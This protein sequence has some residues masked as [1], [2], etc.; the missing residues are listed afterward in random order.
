V[1]LTTLQTLI[2]QMAVELDAQPDGPAGLVPLQSAG[3][4]AERALTVVT[5]SREFRDDLNKALNVGDETREV[6]ERIFEDD[7]LFEQFLAVERRLLTDMRIRA[8]LVDAT[9]VN[10]RNLRRS[11]QIADANVD[12]MISTLQQLREQVTM[13]TLLS[14]NVE[15]NRRRLR[16]RLGGVLEALVGVAVAG[17]NGAASGTIILAPVAW[18]SMAA[19]GAIAAEGYHRARGADKAQ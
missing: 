19:G 14:T 13:L 3:R 4:S 16:R 5:E 8:E 12:G 9:M 10:M 15:K 17:G 18:A 6:A 2:E 1:Y 7:F 11:I